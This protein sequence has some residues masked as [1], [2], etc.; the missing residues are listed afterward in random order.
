MNWLQKLSQRDP[1]SMTNDEFLAH[2]NTGYIEPYREPYDLEKIKDLAGDKSRYPILLKRMN[3]SGMDV[4]FRQREEKQN[5]V[6]TDEEGEIVRDG[7]GLATYLDDEEVL[8]K[9]VPLN[10]PLIQLWVGDTP[11][12]WIGPSFGATELFIAKEL[13]QKGLGSAALKLW[14]EM[15]P[16]RG[17]K[18]SILGQMT[19][20]GQNT[21]RKVHRDLVDEAIQRGEDVPD[22]IR[23]EHAI[24][25]ARPQHERF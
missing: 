17:H 10:D 20:V 5:Y 2:H 3:I 13:W 23:E 9:D 14:L 1:W 7:R 15:Y 4:E 19:G 6:R 21:V 8:E 25:S 11:V 24:S 18:P 22:N 16:T 12:G